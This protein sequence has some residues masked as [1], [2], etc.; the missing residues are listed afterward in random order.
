MLENVGSQSVCVI[1]VREYLVWLISVF[2]K[3]YPLSAI[4][5][6]FCIYR[7]QAKLAMLQK[8]FRLHHTSY[9]IS[10]L[11]AGIGICTSHLL[12]AIKMV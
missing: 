9:D 4:H 12:F 5:D 1:I 10:A 7:L 2:H 11:V 8:N 6:C 3:L